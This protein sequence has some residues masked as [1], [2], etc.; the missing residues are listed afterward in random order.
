M[1]D[2]RAERIAAAYQGR[3]AMTPTLAREIVAVADRLGAH[4]FDLANVINFESGFNPAIENIGCAKKYGPGSGKC[5]TGLIQFL[6]STAER[7]G[8][9]VAALARMDASAQLPYV[10]RYFKAAA[11]GLPLDTVQ[12]VFMAVFRPAAMRSGLDT[13]FPPNVQAANPGIRTV[14]DYVNKALA[15]A[16]LPGSHQEAS[17][18]AAARAGLEEPQILPRIG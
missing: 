11:R 15:K 9:T 7:V 14:G 16:R 8:T 13:A 18:A 1:P 2:T 5:A 4:A 17:N 6:P 12:A 10:E 3:G